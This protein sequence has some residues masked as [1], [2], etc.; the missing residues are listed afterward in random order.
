MC[1]GLLERGKVASHSFIHYW[2][3]IVLSSCEERLAVSLVHFLLFSAGVNA[4]DV[5][6]PARQ[7]SPLIWRRSI[8]S[9]VRQRIAFRQQW[10]LESF[11]QLVLVAS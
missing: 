1:K 6:T 7:Q 5:S 3:R 4:P 11:K 9:A 2:T 8:E 10:P